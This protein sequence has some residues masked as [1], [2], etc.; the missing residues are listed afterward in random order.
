MLMKMSALV[1]RKTLGHVF[2]RGRHY[3]GSNCTSYQSEFGGFH[4]WKIYA[5]YVS[6][7]TCVAFKLSKC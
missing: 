3:R 4:D 5:W 6:S 1:E 2:R 7:I